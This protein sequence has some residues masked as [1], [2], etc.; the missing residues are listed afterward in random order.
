MGNLKEKIRLIAYS[1]GVPVGYVK[2]VSYKT[3]KYTLTQDRVF[4]KT[5]SNQDRAMY[6]ID[7]ITVFG[8]NNGVVFSM[9][10]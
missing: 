3:G 6:D 1:N 8:M 2:S 5:Y 10:M 4:A 7:C 9:T